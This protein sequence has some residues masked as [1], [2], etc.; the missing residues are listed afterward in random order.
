MRTIFLTQLLRNTAPKGAKSLIECL[1]CTLDKQERKYSI[2]D[3]KEI[4]NKCWRTLLAAVLFSNN[5]CTEVRNAFLI[6]R[7]QT[8]LLEHSLVQTLLNPHKKKWKSISKYYN[9]KTLNKITLT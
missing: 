5:N 2:D 3:V 7:I 4:L 1:H 8:E 9:K 6:L